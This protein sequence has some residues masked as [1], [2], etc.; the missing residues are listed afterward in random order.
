MFFEEGISSK[1]FT[2]S[3]Q[4]YFIAAIVVVVILLIAITFLWLGT[5]EKAGIS[6][7]FYESKTFKIKFF[8]HLELYQKKIEGSSSLNDIWLVLTFKPFLLLAGSAVATT[9]CVQVKKI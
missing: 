6:K 9:T 8:F 7:Y 3:T 5:Q 4:K 2:Y 1:A